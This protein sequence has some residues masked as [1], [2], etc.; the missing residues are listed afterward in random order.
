MLGEYYVKDETFIPFALLRSLKKCIVVP[1]KGNGEV[2][3][4]ETYDY[5]ERE[6]NKAAKK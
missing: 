1:N 3:K 2:V 4:Y 6:N 5:I